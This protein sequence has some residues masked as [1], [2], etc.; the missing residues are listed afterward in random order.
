MKKIIITLCIFIA[1][2]FA[3]TLHCGTGSINDEETDSSDTTAPTV[4]LDQ[5]T[6]SAGTVTVTFSEAMAG[7]TITTSSFTVNAE[8][9]SDSDCAT[10]D[11]DSTGYIATCT[12][13]D[14]DCSELENMT[15]TVSTAVTDAAGNALASAFTGTISTLDDG[16]NGTIISDCLD[17]TDGVTNLTVSDGELVA[18]YQSTSTGVIISKTLEDTMFSAAIHM[19]DADLDN[20]SANALFIFGVQDSSAAESNVMGIILGTGGMNVYFQPLGDEENLENADSVTPTVDDFYLCWIRSG[21]TMSAFQSSDGETWTALSMPSS[22]TMTENAETIVNMNMSSI[23]DGATSWIV[24][25]DQMKFLNFESGD[26]M[27]C[28]TF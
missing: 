18:T 24:K 21:Q 13:G 2:V 28:P 14:L 4:T 20:R 16:F 15:V 6:P 26:T 11:Y 22:Y 25:I 3:F 7:G 8:G 27:S 10:V 1:I 17:V 23:E 19:S 5:T 9:A 12:L